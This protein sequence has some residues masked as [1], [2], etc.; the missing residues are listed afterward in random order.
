MASRRFR[1]A[2]RQII[3]ETYRIGK[4]VAD[5]TFQ[6]R[7]KIIL[8]TSLRRNEQAGDWPIYET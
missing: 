6:D 1:W 4:P 3:Q 7:E 5:P 8:D 2:L